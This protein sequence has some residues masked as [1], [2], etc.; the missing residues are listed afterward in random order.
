MAQAAISF[1]SSTCEN[2]KDGNAAQ[3]MTLTLPTTLEN[4]LVIISVAIADDDGADL[5]MDASGALSG[6]GYTEVTD[7]FA[8]DGGSNLDLGVYWKIMGSTPDTSVTIDAQAGNDASVVAV[9]IA[10]RGV[11]TSTPMD[12][13]PVGGAR[14]NTM[15]PDPGPIDHNNP[16]GVWT[17]IAGASAYTGG[18]GAQTYTFPTGYTENAIDRDHNDTTD[19]TVGMGY[20]E[21]GVSDPEDPGAMAHSIA[22]SANFASATTT[23]ALRP[24]RVPTVT[25]QDVS[26]I[27]ATSA[28]FNGTVD[29]TGGIGPTVRGFAWGTNDTMVGDT[30]TTT[31]TAGAPFGTGAFTESGQTLV[32][33][34]TYYY[35]PYA[36]NSIGTST[37]PISN[38]FTTS[39][40]TTPPT[41]TTNFANVGFN[42]ATLHGTKTSGSN[43]TEHGF[44]Y[45]T[46]SEL[47]DGDTAT[48]TL[49]SLS[50]NSS[51]SS[52]VGSLLANTVYFFR[53][54]T[55]N[56]AGTGYGIIRSFTT[57]NSTSTRKMRL[58][59][60]FTIKFI[61]GKIILHQQ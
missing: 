44:A 16:S 49:G 17:V 52:S 33:N 23:I 20:R 3:D 53:A 61:N 15:D 27:G 11:D 38:S 21:S 46:N 39:A 56:G 51:F 10:F 47:L 55:T 57:S 14:I 13:T 37:A 31:D 40:C 58:F 35:R 9:C 45:G 48:T 22:D 2:S 18:D 32:C 34:T 29:A 6:A 41:T 5:D 36:V 1:V 42:S 12:V 25:T 43:A 4:D 26:S 30:A 28:T 54:Y 24:A 50:S 19:G 59:G 60:G 7:V 8:D